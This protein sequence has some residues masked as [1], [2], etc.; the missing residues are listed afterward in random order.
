MLGLDFEKSNDF[1]FEIKID[2][3]QLNHASFYR[4]NIAKT[5]FKQS[6][7][8]SVDFTECDLSVSIFNDCDLL[9]ATFLNTNLEK[10]D[11]RNSKN[12]TID[13]ENNRIK[14]ARFSLQSVDGL[15]SK[16][17]IKIE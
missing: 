9:N 16:Y 7:M 13:P 8:Q 12:F 4:K 17:Q 6:K 15:L 11:F 10:V 3:C 14:G 2:N 5:V 1:A